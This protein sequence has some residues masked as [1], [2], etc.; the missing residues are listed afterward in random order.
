MDGLWREADCMESVSDICGEGEEET[1]LLVVQLAA[2]AV[3]KN[4]G[5]VAVAIGV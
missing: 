1:Q 2:E 5:F 3:C 4:L